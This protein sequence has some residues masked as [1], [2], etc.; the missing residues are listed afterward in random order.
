MLTNREFDVYKLQTIIFT[1]A[2]AS[3]LI[4][5]GASQLSSFSVPGSLLG[6]LGLSQVVYVGGIL[7]KPPA[8]GDLDTA[9]TKLR[10]AAET[11][12][13]AKTQN[14]DT[15]ANGN[16]LPTPLPNQPPAVNAQRQYDELADGII[17]M[18]E[19]A[20]EV[21]ADRSKL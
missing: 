18:I 2:V 14:T 7:V 12:A 17:P 1:V 6:V 10:A 20:L 4:V 9:I 13:T 8:V 11:L 3:A 16:L 15:D 21:P 19:S 5:D